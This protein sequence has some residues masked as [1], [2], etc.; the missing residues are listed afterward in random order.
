[1]KFYSDGRLEYPNNPATD[2]F[3]KWKIFSNGDS[4]KLSGDKNCVFAPSSDGLTIND[5]LLTFTIHLRDTKNEQLI[6]KRID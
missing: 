6:L 2:I 1:M 3:S 5:S 4:I